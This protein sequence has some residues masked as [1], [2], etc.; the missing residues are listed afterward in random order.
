[1]RQ[2][3]STAFAA[4]FAAILGAGPVAAQDAGEGAELYRFHCAMCH[5]IEGTGAGPMAPTLTIQPTDLTQLAAREG[6]VFPLLRV[7]RR[8]DGRDPLVAHGS[9]MPVWGEFFEGRGAD[10][11]MKLPDGQPL[12]MPGP[13]A[14]LVAFIEALQK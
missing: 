10:V 7:V 1:M 11:A 4:V 2:T 8:I 6:G 13:V 14:D 12:L 3:R 9:P 5:G